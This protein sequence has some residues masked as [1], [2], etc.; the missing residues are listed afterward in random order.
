MSRQ[1][2]I[3]LGE[4][5]TLYIVK[6]CDFG[7]YLGPTPNEEENKVL[8]PKRQVP[9][10]AQIGDQIEVFIYKDSEDRII[11][12]VATPSMTLGQVAVCKVKEVAAIGAFL[13]WGLAKDLLLPFKEQTRKVQKGDLALV[14][15][16]IDK[17]QRLAATMNVYEYLSTDSPYKKE[18][19]VTGTVYLVS[20]EFG[21]FVA[22]DNIYSGLI[23][24]KQL[25]KKLIPGQEISARVVEVKEDG[26][27]DLS[28]RE[29]IPV[30]MDEDAEVVLAK[31]E[32]NNGYLGY[33]DKSN[34]EDI[35]LVFG[36][37]KNAFKR[38]VGRLLKEEKIE[39]TDTGIKL[40]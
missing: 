25:F 14:A 26:K 8:L 31:L 21:A 16:Y 10:Q 24:T 20:E 39:L 18:D 22:V 7:V 23:P 40:K 34:P 17:S 12:T 2:E 11:A 35:K 1:N 4:I 38:A 3:R 13:E 9:E 15:L 19:K 33:H 27:L 32:R 28:I 37:S 36:L 5:Q 30:Q 6:R 29:K